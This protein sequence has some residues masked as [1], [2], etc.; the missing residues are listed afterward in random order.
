MQGDNA[1]FTFLP[2]EVLDEGVSSSLDEDAVSATHSLLERDTSV[3]SSLL[4]AANSR[5]YKP[6][7]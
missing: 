7:Y 3:A 2:L 6:Y 5:N 1:G 4:V